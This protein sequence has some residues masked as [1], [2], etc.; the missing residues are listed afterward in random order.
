MP[1]HFQDV[2]NEFISKKN[3][4][5]GFDQKTVRNLL[6]GNDEKIAVFWTESEDIH[7]ST[8]FDQFEKDVY[9]EAIKLSVSKYVSNKDSAIS[10]F[11]RLTEY[12]EKE[13]GCTIPIEYPPIPVSNTLERLLFIAKFFHDEN[14]S[15]E[16][17]TDILWVGDRTIEA[18]LAKL[19]GMDD[20]PLQICGKK[21]TIE[22]MERS[23]GKMSF[24]STVHPFFLTCN[25]TQVMAMLKGLDVLSE[26]PEWRGYVKLLSNQIWQ[27]LSGYGKER[28]KTVLTELM[29][30]EMGLVEKLDMNLQNS[31]QTESYCSSIGDN[32]IFESMKGGGP[33][34]I[35][36]KTKDGSEFLENVE[37]LRG[38]SDTYTVQ[39]NG[40]ERILKRERILKSAMCKER[41][42]S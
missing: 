14:R 26:Q 7:T 15:V 41:M 12:V 22:G 3:K 27:Q 21:F 11:K 29:P 5:R 28:V 9:R 25:L 35:E 34:F 31:F 8:V 30:E 32:A 19:R 23:N 2:I 1:N 40:Q 38:N 4:Y 6:L 13:M 42:F 33:C 17:L 20:D 37:V 24:S 36:Y 39:I 10:I 18:D 16:E